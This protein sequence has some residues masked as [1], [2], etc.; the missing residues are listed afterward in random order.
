VPDGVD[1]A[2]ALAEA[3]P[4]AQSLESSAIAG[5]DRKVGLAEY[6]ERAERARPRD[7]SLTST[8]TDLVADVSTEVAHAPFDPAGP[9]TVKGQYARVVRCR[10]TLGE[11]PAETADAITRSMNGRCERTTLFGLG[12]DYRRMIDG[13]QPTGKMRVDAVVE[14]LAFCG[15]SLFPVRGDGRKW[16][17][18]RGWARGQFR[19]WA[20]HPPLDRWSIDALLDLVATRPVSTAVIAS[21]D[22]VRY[23]KKSQSEYAAAYASK[24]AT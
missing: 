20:W 12:F 19:W 8:V 9:G 14:V 7:L 11:S 18:Q 6:V 16:P 2:G 3:L 22:L 1:L 21:Y 17:I 10:E 4:T 13:V 23:K 15:L 5:M 24:R